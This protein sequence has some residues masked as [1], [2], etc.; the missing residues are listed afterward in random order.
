MHQSLKNIW[1]VTRIFLDC[2]PISYYCTNFVPRYM[3]GGVYTCTC[4]NPFNLAIELW[5][6]IIQMATH[7]MQVH[8]KTLWMSLAI[9]GDFEHLV[10]ADL[11]G[12]VSHCFKVLSNWAHYWEIID[13]PGKSAAIYKS[14]VPHCPW[15]QLWDFMQY[16]SLR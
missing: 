13:L 1:G 8:I 5:L 4:I 15:L 2:D 7:N 3:K 9:I 10:A 12:K 6:H 14:T 11:P 16:I